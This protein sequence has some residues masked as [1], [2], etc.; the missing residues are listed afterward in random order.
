MGGQKNSL[1]EALAQ[2]PEAAE[3]FFLGEHRNSGNG[4]KK[5]HTCFWDPEEFVIQTCSTFDEYYIL[6]TGGLSSALTILLL[7][8]KLYC[9]KGYMG[10]GERDIL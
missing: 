10:G 7:I 2:G 9:T 1:G 8:S 5:L 6:C 4:G 3:D